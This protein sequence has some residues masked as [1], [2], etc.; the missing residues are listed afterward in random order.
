MGVPHLGEG[1]SA[2]IPMLPG[3]LKNILAA[4]SFMA[5]VTGKG[6]LSPSKV[7]AE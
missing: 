1:S 4:T 5:E 2:F 7:G 6:V 3:R